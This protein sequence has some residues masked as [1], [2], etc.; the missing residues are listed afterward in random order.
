MEAS[1]SLS[2][3]QGVKFTGDKAAFL[4]AIRKVEHIVGVNSTVPE[5]PASSKKYKNDLLICGHRLFTRPRSFPTRRDSCCCERRP[6]SSAG[7]SI[8]APSL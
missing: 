8:T 6:K 3:P 5:Q 4:E 1:R 7:P 2:G